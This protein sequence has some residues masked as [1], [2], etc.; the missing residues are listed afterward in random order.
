MAKNKES[1]SFDKIKSFIGVCFGSRAMDFSHYWQCVP[2]VE[3]F[4]EKIDR[5]LETIIFD[6]D[7]TLVAPYADVDDKT[8]EKLREYQKYYQIIIFSNSP[9]SPRLIKLQKDGVDVADSK[10][11]KPTLEA[12]INLAFF[13]KFDSCKTAMVGNF[14]LTDMPLVKNGEIPFFPINILIKSIPPQRKLLKSNAKFLRAYS[15][16]LLAVAVTKIVLFR[17]NFKKK[18]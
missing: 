11:G 17:N 6:L 8:L 13:Y 12:F 5:N 7:G 10:I 16:H 18:F 2:S 9:T 14:P 4:K 3:E 1:F 15:F